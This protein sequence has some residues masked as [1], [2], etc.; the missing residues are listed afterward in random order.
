[1]CLPIF[2]HRIA[3]SVIIPAASSA[4]D[5]EAVADKVIQRIWCGRVLCVGFQDT[6]FLTPLKDDV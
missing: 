6:G 1:M 5:M 4:T 3:C 2:D